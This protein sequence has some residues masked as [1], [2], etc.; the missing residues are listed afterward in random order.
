M[1]DSPAVLQKT[2]ASKYSSKLN[3]GDSDAANHSS[4]DVNEMIPSNKK[5]KSVSQ[6]SVLE[7]NSTLVLS[8]ATTL[9]LTEYFF[10]VVSKHIANPMLRGPLLAILYLLVD[11]GAYITAHGNEVVSEVTNV[12][13]SIRTVSYIPNSIREWVSLHLTQVQFSDN[14]VQ[15]AL[16]EGL[17][18]HFLTYFH[19]FK[20][21]HCCF[22]DLK[23]LLCQFQPESGANHTLIA[24]SEFLA[25]VV[26]WSRS[27][28]DLVESKILV[29]METRVNARKP[30]KAD[31]IQSGEKATSAADDEDDDEEVGVT[32]SNTATASTTAATK[33]KKKRNNKKKKNAAS[34]DAAPAE[35]PGSC[36]K[37]DLDDIKQKASKDNELT[38]LLCSYAQLDYFI[39]L[40]TLSSTSKSSGSSIKRLTYYFLSCNEFPDG[41]NGEKRTI[42][43]GDEL[44]LL[45]SDMYRAN[46]NDSNENQR[47]LQHLYWYSYLNRAKKL[48]PFN[49]AIKIDLL[50]VLRQI[51]GLGQISN[52]VFGQLGPKY[53]QYDSIGYL[54]TPNFYESGYYTETARLYR[55]IIN[56]HKSCRKECLDMISRGLEHANY[57][58]IMEVMAFLQ[59]CTRSL[60][61]SLARTELPLLDAFLGDGTLASFSSLL[62]EHF[63]PTAPAAAIP[64]QTVQEIE[65]LS[66]V[67]HLDNSILARP[68]S[69]SYISHN[70]FLAHNSQRE[71]DILLRIKK[72]NLFLLYLKSIFT[73]GEQTATDQLEEAFTKYTALNRTKAAS[74]AHGAA[75]FG[76][77]LFTS[78]GDEM[79]LFDE[80][81]VNALSLAKSGSIG[82]VDQINSLKQLI[83]SR[84]PAILMTTDTTGLTS[85]VVEGV[86]LLSRQWLESIGYFFV[87]NVTWITLCLQLL[88]QKASS[89]SAPLLSEGISDIAKSWKSFLENFRRFLTDLI[90]RYHSESSL[91][92]AKASLETFLSN[93]STAYPVVS[94]ILQESFDLALEEKNGVIESYIEIN[95]AQKHTLERYIDILDKRIAALP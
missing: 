57:N 52:D 8:R 78:I 93:H 18:T 26:A 41:V 23:P 69:T 1:R 4:A 86:S 71:Q 40:L 72:N 80:L 94:G 47:L 85:S 38:K 92:E 11:L 62:S 27:E 81:L 43:P 56:F 37:I 35:E 65:G 89:S 54:A 66:L 25:A 61:L 14:K 3:F 10:F 39:E 30:V 32:A 83:N 53:M 90:I 49:S 28:L 33:K 75:T 87:W 15:K 48:S 82:S 17:L 51:G 20:T 60:H 13:E 44:I 34:K 55:C 2:L 24:S 21:K 19:L 84:L 70:T 67:S 16:Y 45:H 5:N 76:Q 59:D 79:S 6:L 77:S 12:L 42:Q 95:S 64:P 29:S 36:V 63:S 31:A 50:D 58:K 68:L 22:L 46:V 74:S 7:H 88:Q 73:A 91:S 9:T